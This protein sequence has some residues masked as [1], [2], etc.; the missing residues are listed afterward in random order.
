[1]TIVIEEIIDQNGQSGAKKQDSA[2][3]LLSELIAKWISWSCLSDT[4]RPM[5]LEDKSFGLHIDD[6]E[7]TAIVTS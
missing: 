6:I 2:N 3:D 4:P 5:G 1:M 7:T